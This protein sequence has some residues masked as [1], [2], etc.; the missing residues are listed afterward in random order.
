MI[1][2]DFTTDKQRDAAASF[3]AGLFQRGI[4]FTAIEEDGALRINL[5]GF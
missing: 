3:C 2:L 1:R 5:E 4:R